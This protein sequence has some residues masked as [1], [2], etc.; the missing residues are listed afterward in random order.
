MLRFEG[1]LCCCRALWS[2]SRFLYMCIRSGLLVTYDCMYVR[3][4]NGISALLAIK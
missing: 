3:L 2:I 4:L 1:N